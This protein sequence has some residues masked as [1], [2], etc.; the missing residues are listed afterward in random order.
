MGLDNSDEMFAH[1]FV[2][3]IRIV[4]YC[5]LLVAMLSTLFLVLG[6]FRISSFS[7]ATYDSI[8]KIPYN[9]VGL[10]LGT[11]ANLAPGGDNQYFTYRILATAELFNAGKISYVLI[12]GDKSAYYDEPTKM[13]QALLK[14]GLPQERLVI[15][16]AGFRPLATEWWHFTLNNEPYPDTYFNFPVKQLE[17]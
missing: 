6:I 3:F 11:A 7:F 10:L 1:E 8:E 16:E 9:R 17:D 12:S 13:Y 5:A 2:R 14:V 4:I 15:D